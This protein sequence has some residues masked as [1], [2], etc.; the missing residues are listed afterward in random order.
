MKTYLLL[1][2]LLAVAVALRV[3]ALR[4]SAT[5]PISPE[6]IAACQLVRGGERS[7]QPGSVP[8]LQSL[9]FDPQAWVIVDNG[10]DG[11]PGRAGIDDDFNGVVDDASERGAFGSDD[12]CHILPPDASPARGRDADVSVLSRG[13]FVPDAREP[14]ATAAP[15][16]WIVSGEADGRAWKF[17]IDEVR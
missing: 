13:G 4:A 2:T 3:D 17:A 8:Q 10:A 14:A 9:R 1:F 5:H 6:L 15:R 7:S 11:Q 16:R 12:Q